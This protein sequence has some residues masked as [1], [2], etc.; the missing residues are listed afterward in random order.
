MN[1]ERNFLCSADEPNKRK[2]M[3]REREREKRRKV[4][5][6]FYLTIILL[7]FILSLG[8]LLVAFFVSS[9][10]PSPPFF[11]F[12][13]SPLLCSAV[14]FNSRSNQKMRM[15]RMNRMNGYLYQYSN[16]RIMQSLITSSS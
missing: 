15:N 5:A 7:S 8:L 1:E 11:S 14:G 3:A 13:F 9:P 12:C 6:F 2:G 10:S 16:Q 4:N